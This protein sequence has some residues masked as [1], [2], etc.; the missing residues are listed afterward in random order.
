MQ[1]QKTYILTQ[2][3]ATKAATL[4]RGLVLNGNFDYVG[5]KEVEIGKNY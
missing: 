5:E 4:H 2:V 3:K 1:I